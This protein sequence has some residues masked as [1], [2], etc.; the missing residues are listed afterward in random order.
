MGLFENVKST[1]DG[2]G[3]VEL[4]GIKLESAGA[5]LLDPSSLDLDS[6]V[7]MQSSAIAYY[8]A[9]KKEA[10]RRLVKVKRDFDRWEKKKYSIAKAAVLM[11]LEKSYKPTVDDIKSRFVTDN[12][13]ELEEWDAKIDQAQ[14]E[15]DTLE[16]WYE[17][18]RQKSFSLKD[19]VSIDEDER[20]NSKD[21]V[22]GEPPADKARPFMGSKAREVQEMLRARKMRQSGK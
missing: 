19:H 18:W 21:S 15:F 11:G 2:M 8:G 6:H 12:E 16:S 9:M 5:S 14:E 10:A 3:Q 20:W 1:I 13:R 17:G 22:V 4:S 7:A